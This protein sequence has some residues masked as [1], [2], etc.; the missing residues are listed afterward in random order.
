MHMLA[1]IS[2]RWTAKRRMARPRRTVGTAETVLIHLS[3]SC[4]SGTQCRERHR[5]LK[6]TFG[7]W[8]VRQLQRRAGG[9]WPT[10]AKNE[11]SARAG[12]RQH[13]RL[14]WLPQLQRA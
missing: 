2:K 10:T 14:R 5:V 11:V 6:E 4:L 12:G 9:E 8:P 7:L 1:H 13:S 3:L